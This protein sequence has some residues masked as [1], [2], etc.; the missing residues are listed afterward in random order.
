MSLIWTCSDE[1]VDAD[2]LLNKYIVKVSAEAKCMTFWM[3]SWLLVKAAVL[4]FTPYHWMFSCVLRLQLGS[5]L[6]A[7][8]AGVVP[9][10][11]SCIASAVCLFDRRHRRRRG[12]RV[13]QLHDPVSRTDVLEDHRRR[14]ERD[15]VS[16]PS[17]RSRSVRT[18]TVNCRFSEFMNAT[19]TRKAEK[20]FWKLHDIS[21]YNNLADLQFVTKENKRKKMPLRSRI[22]L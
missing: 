20:K 3:L 7:V 14:W 11:H 15:S 13:S 8:H 12:E 6:A 2:S 17:A 5:S 9:S 19:R 18:Q 4:R 10:D 22:G 1:N 21:I 16:L